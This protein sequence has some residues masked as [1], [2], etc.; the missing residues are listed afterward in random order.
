MGMI[1]VE[2][3]N[4]VCIQKVGF[5]GQYTFEMMIYIN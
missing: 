3:K 4:Q 5:E 2:E 1:C